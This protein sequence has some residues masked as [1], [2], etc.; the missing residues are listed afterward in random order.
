MF[1]LTGEA[2]VIVHIS[3]PTVDGFIAAVALSDLPAAVRRG[4]PPV[5][6][7]VAFAAELLSSMCDHA[8]QTGRA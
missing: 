8:D 5:K 7:P 4:G 1:G 3:L 2:I 6:L